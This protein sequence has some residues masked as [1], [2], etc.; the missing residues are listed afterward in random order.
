MLADT[1]YG[2]DD[3][4]EKAKKIGVEGI[5]PVCGKVKDDCITLADFDFLREH[6]T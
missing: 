4:C 1:A 2:S 5:S 6:Q 3:N